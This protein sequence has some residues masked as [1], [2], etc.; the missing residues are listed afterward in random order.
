M[1]PRFQFTTFH[2]IAV[3]LVLVAAFSYFFPEKVARIVF[4][5]DSETVVVGENELQSTDTILFDEDV[6]IVDLEENPQEEPPE[7]ATNAPIEETL[8]E[9]VEQPVVNQPL[10]PETAEEPPKAP[11]TEPAAQEKIYAPVI[12]YSE[13]NTLT[14]NA[15][16]NIICTTKSGGLFRPSSGSGVIVDERGIILT[17]A[18]VAQYYLLEDYISE[19]FFECIIRTGSPAVATYK[20]RPLY[21][22]EQWVK[23]NAF[24]LTQTN[25]VGNG[26]H[27]FAFLLI[28]ERTDP[29]AALPKKFPYVPLNLDGKIALAGDEVLIAGYPAG[30]LSGQS[31]QKDLYQASTITE[32]DDVFTFSSQLIDLITLGGVIVAQGGSSGSPVVNWEAKVTGLVVT[33]TDG[34]TTADRNLAA[35]TT[36]H[37]NRSLIE[38]TGASISVLFEQDLLSQVELFESSIKPALTALLEA[39][40]E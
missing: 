27:D 5:E 4:P 3:L 9:P 29:A 21:L 37:I 23:D 24:K 1:E 10:A 2:L 31:I 26:E 7:E 19:D 34:D 12:P 14:R 25:P 15:T 22:S 38:Q 35:I 20:A 32:V 13:M 36:S 39:E 6:S 40:L 33:S 18:H 17:N 28:T 30:F 8:E 16:V 11:I